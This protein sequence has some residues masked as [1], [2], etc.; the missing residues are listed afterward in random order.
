METSLGNKIAVIYGGGGAIGG[1]VVRAHAIPGAAAA[2]SHSRDV[3][4]P[5]AERAG[6]TIEDM[7]SGA[8]GGTLLKRLPALGEMAD[9]AVFLALHQAGAMTGTVAN[10]TCGYLVD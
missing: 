5:V 8:A 6:V 1:A 9:T 2:G 10:L 3:F 4:R 7:L